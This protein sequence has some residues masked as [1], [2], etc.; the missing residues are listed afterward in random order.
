MEKIIFTTL[1]AILLLA[2]QAGLQAAGNQQFLNGKPFSDLA[3]LINW[4][5]I[6][7]IIDRISVLEASGPEPPD[8]EKLVFSGH[9]IMGIT[10][11]VGSQLVLDWLDFTSKAI[12]DYTSI[13][14]RG[15]AGGGVSCSDSETATAIAHALSSGL[16]DTLFTFNCENRV[17][18]VGPGNPMTGGGGIELNAGSITETG[19][20]LEE[21]SVRPLMGNSNWG[22]I[23][24]TC[25]A[26]SQTLEVILTLK[27]TVP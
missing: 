26:P 12:G 15:S 23:G 22:G 24:L 2:P 13:E 11:A 16:R 27:N 21:A 7:S 8:G 17:W 20:C 5:E 4:I 25:V 14:I 10:P 9:F 1:F 3:D 18:N 19:T 6:N